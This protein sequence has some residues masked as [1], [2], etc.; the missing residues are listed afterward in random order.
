M[1]IVILVTFLI[2]LIGAK[3]PTFEEKVEQYLTL[4]QTSNGFVQ[5]RKSIATTYSKRTGY[6]FQGI[7][8]AKAPIDSLRYQKPVPHA[9]W[10]GILNATTFGAACL[11]NSSVTNQLPNY[12]KT[13]EDCLFLNIYTSKNCLL[14]GNCSVAVYV[15]GGNFN[16]DSP[17]ILLEDSLI[18]NFA[19]DQRNVIFVSF[20][21]R[22]GSFGFLNLNYKLNL[23]IPKNQG[24]F[25]MV[26]A[27]KWTKNEI[28]NFG[29]SP[30]KITL[31]GHS[32]GS[33]CAAGLYIS[34]QAKGLFNKAMFMSGTRG[35]GYYPDNNQ[36]TSRTLAGLV[37]CA[38][39]N[40][41]WE[42]LEV[43]EEIITCLKSKPGQLLID[44]QAVVES[45]G[46]RVAG[47]AN[48]FGEDAFFGKTFAELEK[49][50]P[51]VPVMTG[52]VREEMS[53]GKSLIDIDKK[54]VSF[55]NK[56]KLRIFCEYTLTTKVFK[57]Q[58]LAVEA[59]VDHYGEDT[60]K[61]KHIYDDISL[62]IKH[63]RDAR[64]ATLAG[65]KSYLYQFNY[66]QSGDAMF[67]SKEY[68]VPD[69]DRPYHSEELIYLVGI[70]K[71]TFAP[72]DY[73]IQEKFSELITNFIK[74][75][76]PSSENITF[77]AFDATL[78]NY[79]VIDFDE[80]FTMPG[81][82]NNFHSEADNFWNKE[83]INKAGP[84]VMNMHEEA[85]I[86]FTPKINEIE[87]G[88]LYKPFTFPD[89]YYSKK[90]PKILPII[91]FT[92]MSLPPTLPIT[93]DGQYSSIA[94]IFMVGFFFLL[95]ILLATCILRC[96][97][98]SKRSKY[99]PFV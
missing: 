86:L 75:G 13:S 72:K 98:T 84:Y 4:R 96:L 45:F 81:M 32:S 87:D 46:V 19:N 66:N 52:V 25:D 47:Y 55:V 35:N 62:F 54:N 82:T 21:Y 85:Q 14:K 79:Y 78:N 18:E 71:G 65:A 95:L 26:E 44:N 48:D 39:D 7:P 9:P 51:K 41:D 63:L 89:E 16:F 24:M 12:T 94:T 30:D 17:I 49:D 50:L 3:V 91:P 58:T 37:G 73:I 80:N 70:H 28:A 6:V 5:G 10:S 60:Y 99:E 88:K 92:N 77:D 15:H 56:T 93:E 23:S 90:T 68:A 1:R 57:N 33:I 43:V 27:L 36:N 64:D 74:N 22:E 59:C 38:H 97:N 8:Y 69:Q 76:Y 42:S 83:I 53:D 20:S 67:L 11:W 34:P 31:T 29:G 61:A 40:T 2:G